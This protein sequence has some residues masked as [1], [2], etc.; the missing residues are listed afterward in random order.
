MLESQLEKWIL[1]QATQ[2]LPLALVLPSGQRIELGAPVTVEIRLRDLNW[3]C[4]L[5]AR[6]LRVVA[7]LRARDTFHPATVT[8]DGALTLD[9][10]ALAAPGQAAVF[11]AGTR[12]LGGGFIL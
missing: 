3:L 9:E 7:K 6:P 1:S 2:R 5:P 4:P 11:Y 12:I 8:A 10:P